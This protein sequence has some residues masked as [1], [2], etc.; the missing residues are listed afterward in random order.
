[1]IRTFNCGIG[2]CIIAPKKNISRIKR[3][4]NREFKPYEIGYITK[5][6]DRV[7]LINFLKW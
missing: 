1:M 4:F 7:N 5:N 2:F 6:Y 3:L